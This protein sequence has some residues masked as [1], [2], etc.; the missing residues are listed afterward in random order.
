MARTIQEQINDASRHLASLTRDLGFK[1]PDRLATLE[2]VREL[3]RECGRR[4]EAE[5]AEAER[6]AAEYA[7][8]GSPY[9][10]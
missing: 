1:H 10:T 3:Q 4:K 9:S 6:T 5:F 8:Y 2:V 7:A